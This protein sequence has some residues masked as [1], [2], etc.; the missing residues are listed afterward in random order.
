[1]T[2]LLS[3]F[4]HFPAKEHHA[5]S[6]QVDRIKDDGCERP[7]RWTADAVSLMVAQPIPSSHMKL[8][9]HSF[10]SQIQKPVPCLPCGHQRTKLWKCLHRLLYPCGSTGKK[11]VFSLW[12][13][14]GMQKGN[15]PLLNKQVDPNVFH[16][17]RRNLLCGKKRF[18]SHSLS[19]KLLAN[20]NYKLNCS[21]FF[22]LH[23]L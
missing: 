18:V 14:R 5:L 15:K 4:A 8:P 6:T 22:Y 23:I 20:C 12:K 16:F 1:M 17:F 3:Y 9:L 7:Q 21:L 2:S 13:A 19:A 11:I 10:I